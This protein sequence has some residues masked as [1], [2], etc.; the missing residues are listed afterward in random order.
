MHTATLQHRHIAHRSSDER[1]GRSDRG[2][3]VG[4]VVFVPLSCEKR[5]QTRPNSRSKPFTAAGRS[6]HDSLH[7]RAKDVHSTHEG[8]TD[9]SQMDTTK[10]RSQS[11]MFTA[12]SPVLSSSERA[13]TASSQHRALP[14]VGAHR[15]RRA[16]VE[17][18]PPPQ[19]FSG[20]SRFGTWGARGA[21]PPSAHGAPRGT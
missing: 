16:R 14:V 3:D 1:C 21:R 11:H 15:L 10:L 6:P 19:H 9:T 18:P 12:A 4:D 8:P 7:P 17:P 13:S 5:S 2:S 20:G